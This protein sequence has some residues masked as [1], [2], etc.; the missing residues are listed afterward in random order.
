MALAS[1][2]L[3]NFNIHFGTYTL[4]QWPLPRGC[5]I[6]WYLTFSFSLILRYQHYIITIF[7]WIKTKSCHTRLWTVARK[8]KYLCT[9]NKY[10]SPSYMNSIWLWF[11]CK[12]QIK[13]KVFPRSITEYQSPLSCYSAWIVNAVVNIVDALGGVHVLSPL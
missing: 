5:M 10:W 1:V 4:A 6:N 13:K 9:V 7:N 8:L 11:S 12:L 2:I 3:H